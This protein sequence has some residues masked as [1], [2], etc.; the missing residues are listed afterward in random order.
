[1]PRF[2]LVC[3]AVCLAGARAW[4]GRPPAIVG[5]SLSAEEVRSADPRALA[6]AIVARIKTDCDD[7]QAPVGP[8]PLGA[9]VRISVMVPAAALGSIA[10]FGLRNQHETASGG[11]KIAPAVRFEA[12]QELAMLRLPYGARGRALLPKYAFLSSEALG[13]PSPPTRYGGVE[14]VLKSEVESRA[15]WTYADSLDFWRR[16]GLYEPEGEAN[17]VLPHSF[18]YRRRPRDH[19]SCVNYCEAQIWGPVTLDDVAYA[20]VPEGVTVPASFSRRTR[21]VRGPRAAADARAAPVD[22][23]RRGLAQAALS[24]AQ[25]IAAVAASSGSELGRLAG[26]LS[27]RPS[28]LAIRAAFARLSKSRDALARE[29]ALY[30]LASGPWEQFKPHLL[31]ALRDDEPAVVIEAAA[32]ALPR[33]SES[34]VAEALKSLRAGLGRFEDSDRR[35]IAE[36]LDRMTAP[37]LCAPH[38]NSK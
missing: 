26:D 21:I 15:T 19:N 35:R 3:A 31:V 2:V 24:D 1:M 11:G 38:P 34:E 16:A 22:G 29:I 27:E 10:E 13:N 5:L 20:V 17:S 36:W 7:A 32:L 28:T 37:A 9:G 25:L 33:R 8:S 6:R 14:L 18:S 4:A 12:E 30:G 23:L